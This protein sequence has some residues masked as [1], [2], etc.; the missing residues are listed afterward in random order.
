[1]ITITSIDQRILEKLVMKLKSSDA[2]AL[3]DAMILTQ[4]AD[5]KLLEAFEQIKAFEFEN[6]I[7][8]IESLLYKTPL[9]KVC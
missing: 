4:S 6:A 3:D 1:L 5:A 9:I 2:T 7:V 8:L